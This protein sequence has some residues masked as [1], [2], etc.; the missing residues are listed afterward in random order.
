MRCAPA[1]AMFSCCCNVLT[2]PTGCSSCHVPASIWVQEARSSL[3]AFFSSG[4]I[5]IGIG[6]DIYIHT[7]IYM[8]ADV[9]SVV[10]LVR[11][12][13]PPLHSKTRDGAGCRRVPRCCVH[14]AARRWAWGFTR[15]ARLRRYMR[16]ALL[17][18]IREL[19]AH[20]REALFV[21]IA[22]H[23][24]VVAPRTVY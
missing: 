13:C 5:L 2:M 23:L 16:L 24:P 9:Y 6:I 21:D 4:S 14:A 1:A 3:R 22:A 19:R 17:V 18:A 8:H 12:H 20:I 7:Y 15:V 11:Y 10:T